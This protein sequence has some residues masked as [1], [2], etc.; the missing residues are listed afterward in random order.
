M[1]TIRNIPMALC[2]GNQIKNKSVLSA[3]LSKWEITA[4][5]FLDNDF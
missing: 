1:T 4:A 5:M 2:E 3:F